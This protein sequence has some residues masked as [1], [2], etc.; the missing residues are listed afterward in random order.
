MRARTVVMAATAAVLA[1]GGTAYGDGSPVAGVAEGG[2]GVTWGALRYVALPT[3]GGTAVAQI[4]RATGEVNGYVAL[5]G[6]WGI[7]QVAFDGTTAGISVGGQTLVL[8]QNRQPFSGGSSRFAL[9]NAVKM[10]LQRIVTL[11]GA[12]FFDA[13]SPDGG[14]MYLIQLTSSAN[15]LGYAVR[16]YDLRADRLVPGAI[17]DKSEP[18]ERMA[19]FPMSRASS[20]DGVWAYTLYQEPQGRMF[21]HALDTQAGVAHCI[22]LPRLPT[23]GQG[24]MGLS[25][26][27]GR[28]DVV[29]DGQV[30]ARVDTSTF[31]VIRSQATATAAA[32]EQAPRPAAR[33]SSDASRVW[34]VLPIALVAVGGAAFAVRR[35]RP[36]RGGRS[37]GAAAGAPSGP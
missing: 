29:S 28:L 6:G 1:G 10:R 26:S 7:P 4:D 12:F 34:I 36:T 22:D 24:M 3:H 17:V 37:G 8:G 19:G 33:G 20:A 2:P 23:T 18:D 5:R 21:I 32:A 14:S 9:V 25:L 11:R 13:I 31:D 16:A 15:A 30:V 27:G 35:R